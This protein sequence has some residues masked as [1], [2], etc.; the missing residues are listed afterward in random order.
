[1]NNLLVAILVPTVIAGCY[2]SAGRG[3]HMQDGRDDRADV[4][5]AEPDIAADG[6]ETQPDVQPEG[7]TCGNGIL[8]AGEECD[9]SVLGGATCESLGLGGGSLSCS[10]ACRLDV[11][12]CS[13]CGNGTCDLGESHERCPGDC[14]DPCGNGSCEEA[15][16]QFGCPADCGALAISSMGDHACALLA[17]GTV[18]C[19]GSN[20]Y[21]QLGDGRTDHSACESHPGQADCS[22]VPVTVPGLTDVVAV[23][24]GGYHTCAV[25]EDGT[26][27]CWGR[28][29]FGQLGNGTTTASNVPVVVSDLIGAAAVSV[30]GYHTCALLADGTARC[31]GL[32]WAGQLGD[33]T[34]TDSNVPAAVSDLAG[35]EDISSANG[36]RCIN[37]F[38][39]APVSGGSSCAVVSGGTAL[40]WG[41]GYFGQ[42]GDGNYANSN[43][44]IA[45][46]GLATVETVSAGGYHSCAL[47]SDGTVFCWG[48][49]FQGELGNGT[50]IESGVP[51]AVPGLNGVVDVVAGTAFTCALLFDGTVHCWGQDYAYVPMPIAGLTR[52]L[53]ISAGKDNLTCALLPDGTVWCWGHNNW[54]ELGDGTTTESSI[55]VRVAA[56]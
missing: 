7:Y 16:D 10:D 3:Q 56:W 22:K 28:N 20:E 25:V 1:M 32:N 53:A 30:G 19:W 54:G 17:D 23:S 26:A 36:A 15:E 9:G 47:L 48:Q 44:P 42:L 33:G 46:A 8:E 34:N 29:D 4:D 11:S 31:W 35:A 39:P 41:A 45:V 52:V 18:R 2:M 38:C 14:L 55:P 21:G 49:N 13:L 51:V 12:D 6:I 27:R 5:G 37:D 40:C 50:T 24:A 43:V